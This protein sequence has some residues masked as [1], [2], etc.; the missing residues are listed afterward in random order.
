MN[1]GLLIICTGKY[2]IFFNS[3]YESCE[4]HFLKNHKKTYYVFTDDESIESKSNIIKIN[5][6]RLGW[7]FDTLKRFSIFNKSKELLIKEDYLY[8]LNANMLCVDDVNEEIIPSVDNNYLA[9]VQHPGFYSESNNTF[10]YERNTKSNFYIPYGQGKNY[11]QGCF[12]GGRSVEFLNMSE[13][14]DKLI[15]S[16]VE[17]NIIPIWWDESALNWYY[18]DKN[19]L[20]I[21][22]HYAYPED[23]MYIGLD[24]KK[25]KILNRDKSK[26]GG[27]L[28]LREK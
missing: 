8:F 18:L 7:P 21:D 9:A 15:D 26:F 12:I 23:Q 11:Y 1:I 24:I 2:S 19:P 14:L 28:F 3:L 22:R 4:K 13:Y 10:T 25:T 17:N 6:N 27:H 16:D 20:I 5:Q